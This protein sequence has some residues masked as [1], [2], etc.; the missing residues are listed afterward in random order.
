VTAPFPWASLPRVDRRAPRWIAA[1]QA[2][3]TWAGAGSVVV[4]RGRRTELV[5]LGIGGAE[6][7]GVGS[8]STGLGTHVGDPTACAVRVGKGA[9]AAHLVMPGRLVRAIAQRLLGGPDELDAP[10]PLTR[11]E[12][13]VAPV[14][15]AALLDLLEAR[16]VAVDAEVVDPARLPT[17][18]V[19]EIA[20]TG[21]VAATVA[22][23]LPFSL[24]AP[25][26]SPLSEIA[27]NRR[28]WLDGAM[29]SLPVVLAWAVLDYSSYSELKAR[30]VIVATRFVVGEVELRVARGGIRAGLARTNGRLTVLS[31]YRRGTMDETLGDDA[32][33]DLAISVGDVRMSVRSLMELRPGQVLELGRPVGSAVELRIGPKV[34]GRGEL[35]DVEGDVGVR[36]L[37]ID[38]TST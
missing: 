28:S 17:E 20:V 1:V 23:I 35:V 6:I 7:V 10:R 29:V 2:W 4:R 34:V 16:D 37:S 38:S 24:T 31:S 33:I 26:R 8:P 19:L 14:V 30:D 25:P 18:T 5:D 3:L 12:R 36:V 27:S 9:V 11:I 22:V 32:T 21:D 13:A 15:A